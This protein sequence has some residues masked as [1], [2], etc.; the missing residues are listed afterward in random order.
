MDDLKSY[1]TA[2]VH[3]FFVRQL[4]RFTVAPI[5]VRIKA[6]W[7]VVMEENMCYVVVAP[8][9]ST[10]KKQGTEEEEA[11]QRATHLPLSAPSDTLA[12]QLI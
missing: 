6:C 2:D 4:Y 1:I 9:V 3:D 5:C 8:H 12:D 10:M 7:V 11:L